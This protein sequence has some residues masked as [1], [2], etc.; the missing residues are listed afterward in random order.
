M[1]T[2]K[3][4]NWLSPD[5]STGQLEDRQDFTEVVDFMRPTVGPPQDETHMD[6]DQEGATCP[7]SPHQADDNSPAHN[8]RISEGVADGYTP[9]IGHHH[10]EQ[11]FGMSETQKEKGLCDA[12]SKGDGL[13]WTQEADQH[14]G[15][16]AAGVGHVNDGQV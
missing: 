14:L 9:I 11:T 8:D 5:I 10:Q 16:H 13:G 12:A 1:Q 7:G 15:H 6:Q 2:T 4:T 3:R